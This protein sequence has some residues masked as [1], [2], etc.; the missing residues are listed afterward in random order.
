MSRMEFSCDHAVNNEC[1][2]GYETLAEDCENG[3]GNR[4]IF[5]APSTRT[6]WFSENTAP[7]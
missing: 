3:N 4:A 2:A 7:S 5:R 1:T 6:F